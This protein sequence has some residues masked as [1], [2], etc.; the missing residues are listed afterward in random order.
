VHWFDTAHEDANDSEML[1]FA[2]LLI[3]CAASVASL[4]EWARK[5][6]REKP[7]AESARAAWKAPTEGWGKVGKLSKLFAPLDD[8]YM[9]TS[10]TDYELDT[11]GAAM[12]LWDGAGRHDKLTH[13]QLRTHLSLGRDLKLRAARRDKKM[14]G[15][16]RWRSW[17]I[18]NVAE[19][20]LRHGVALRKALKLDGMEPA[21]VPTYV[22]R[23]RPSLVPGARDVE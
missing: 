20:V 21:D 8:A 13:T 16:L 2:L 10:W 12:R 14:G 11:I 1:F 4:E 19:L 7:A 23:A 22:P 17:T 18:V 6:L 15:P 3:S 9:N 5:V